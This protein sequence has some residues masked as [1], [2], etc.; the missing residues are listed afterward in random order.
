[1]KSIRKEGIKWF[2]VKDDIKIK[3]M[4]CK[5]IYW[6]KFKIVIKREFSRVVN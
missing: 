4:R 1:M 6:I 5:I 2:L 3:F